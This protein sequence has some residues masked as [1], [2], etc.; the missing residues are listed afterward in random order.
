MKLVAALIFF[1]IVSLLAGFVEWLSFVKLRKN[2]VVVHLSD[3]Y[4][5]M[6]RR[7]LPA[8]NIFTFEEN[9]SDLVTGLLCRYCEGKIKL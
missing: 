9:L 6:L 5:K 7:Q 3:R 8:T 4:I 2:H 1:S